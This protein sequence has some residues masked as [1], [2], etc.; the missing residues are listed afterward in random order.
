MRTLKAIDEIE[1]RKEKRKKEAAALDRVRGEA[2]AAA[3]AGLASYPSQPLP[4]PVAQPSVVVPTAVTSAEPDS[5]DAA[6]AEL[7]RWLPGETVE[8]VEGSIPIVADIKASAEAQ[9]TAERA[10]PGI[11]SL[12]KAGASCVPLSNTSTSKLEERSTPVPVRGADDEDRNDQRRSIA[13]SIC[14]GGGDDRN[15]NCSGKKGHAM[16][17]NMAVEVRAAVW[18][19]TG[20]AVEPKMPRC[21]RRQSDRDVFVSSKI[22]SQEIS[23]R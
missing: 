20:N 3:A 6:N 11:S 12:S 9:R 7:T 21:W 2:A 14:D 19:R 15:I 4:T 8:P 1:S 23:S 13:G 22:I 16:Y 17:E 10:S 18:K 5:P